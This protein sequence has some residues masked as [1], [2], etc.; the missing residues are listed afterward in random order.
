V[1][2]GDLTGDGYQD[3]VVANTASNTVS[4]LLNN[5]SGFNNG[6]DPFTTVSYSTGA[7]PN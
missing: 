6:N 4:V 1:A 2:I 7:G 5:G 3:I